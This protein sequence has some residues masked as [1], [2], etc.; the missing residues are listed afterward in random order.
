MDCFKICRFS[1]YFHS[2]IPRYLLSHPNCP[3]SDTFFS[4]ICKN[5][6]SLAQAFTHSLRKK[7]LPIPLRMCR[8]NRLD[9]IFC[10][11]TIYP[12]PQ[13][14]F[15]SRHKGVVTVEQVSDFCP[16]SWEKASLDLDCTQGRREE[17]GEGRWMRYMARWKRGE[18]ELERKETWDSIMMGRIYFVWKTNG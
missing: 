15:T 18:Y 5:P 2:K 6:N 4:W 7:R 3:Q 13:E 9:Y 14:C 1:I 10:H 17:D 11:H 8:P 16:S 12:P